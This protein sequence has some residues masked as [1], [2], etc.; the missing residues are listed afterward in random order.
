MKG[1]LVVRTV[2]M[3]FWNTLSLHY[4]CGPMHHLSLSRGRQAWRRWQMIGL[5]KT[6]QLASIIIF[7][8]PQLSI[9]IGSRPLRASVTA[10][11]GPLPLPITQS[12]KSSSSQEGS[13]KM[14]FEPYWN[15]T[16]FQEIREY[17]VRKRKIPILIYIHYI[18]IKKLLEF[19]APTKGS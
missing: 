2:D 7:G 16:K 18:F 3:G 14:T 4:H 13:R 11:S 10:H 8:L 6:L 15:I 17:G 19:K 12:L 1:V 5:L 9:S